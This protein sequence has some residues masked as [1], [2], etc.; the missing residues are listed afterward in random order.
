MHF[1]QSEG[2]QWSKAVWIPGPHLDPSVLATILAF[3]DASDDFGHDSQLPVTLEA[4]GANA[5]SFARVPGACNQGQNNVP[6]HDVS[7]M[8]TLLNESTGGLEFDWAAN[9]GSSI[10]TY[11]MPQHYG[12]GD[13]LNK[14][15]HLPNSP[16]EAARCQ[17]S[18]T[19]QVDSACDISAFINVRKPVS[20][21]SA[22]V[23]AT[24]EDFALPIPNMLPTLAAWNK[25]NYPETGVYAVMAQF[26]VFVALVQD[27]L[28]HSGAQLKRR[29]Y[30]GTTPSTVF[31]PTPY[32]T[33]FYSSR[34]QLKTDHYLGTRL[35]LGLETLDLAAY[36]ASG[37]SVLPN[38]AIEAVWA[39]LA[40][41]THHDYI[42]GTAVDYVV[43]KEQLPLGQSVISQA[44]NL[45]TKVLASL[46]RTSL[47]HPAAAD[48]HLL[49][50]NQNGFP[51]S[52]VVS[53]PAR[54]PTTF[55]KSPL[56]QGGHA[57]AAKQRYMYVSDMGAFSYK[58]VQPAL[59][60]DS[61]PAPVTLKVSSTQIIL[62]NGLV[63]YSLLSSSYFSRCYSATASATS[64]W[65]I[66]SL[67]DVASGQKVLNLGNSLVFRHDGGNIYRYVLIATILRSRHVTDS[68][69]TD[70]KRD[71]DS[72]CTRSV[73]WPPRP[74][75][76]R[77]ALS[78]PLRPLLSLCPPPI[79]L[80]S[81]RFLPHLSC[82][83][84]LS[85]QNYTLVYSLRADEPFLRMSLTG[86]SLPSSVTM[87]AFQFPRT[88]SSYMHGTPT[89][90]DHKA[91]RPFGK[92]ADF[93]VTVCQLPFLPLYLPHFKMEATHDF[94][95]PQS[96]DD[97][98]L[99]AVYHTS[100]PSW[101]V[102]DDTLY[103]VLLR[104][105]PGSFGCPGS[106]LTSPHGS[107]TLPRLWC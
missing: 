61:A 29:N 76:L 79:P 43:A 97:S 14:V 11:F 41:S 48:D 31:R 77:M 6:A 9:D 37:A 73:Q 15:A 105:S 2:V 36:V 94:I 54:S 85:A 74:P 32:W 25:N 17:H 13:S 10:F 71:V 44:N 95:I 3:A 81:V 40:P 23:V 96:D 92:Q 57:G 30:H 68:A 90:W 45:R 7:A 42:T 75:S 53:L 99:G 78:S 91:P 102:L 47:R 33:G 55:L 4:L 89:H 82:P 46:A 84:F 8:E 88:V 18:V 107:L 1:L 101:G 70:L 28:K 38:G 104:D 27:Q 93:Q 35:L 60:A 83:H 106:L 12:C 103:G 59:H 22:F 64:Q 62:S 21:T 86:A 72:I 58:H 16:S 5:V 100:S 67:I 51:V 80:I 34:P 66:V 63:R 19:C 69:V 24:G 26:D 20:A 52:G 56:V 98:L 87:V 50:F 49:I 39:N 65:A